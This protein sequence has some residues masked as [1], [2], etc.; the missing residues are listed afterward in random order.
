M[1]IIPTGAN[2][3]IFYGDAAVGRYVE[4]IN[5]WSYMLAPARWENLLFLLI[6]QQAP[7]MSGLNDRAKSLVSD[8]NTRLYTPDSDPLSEQAYTNLVWNIM[9]AG[10]GNVHLH[11][12]CACGTQQ[13]SYHW[14]QSLCATAG[15]NPTYTC[16]SFLY[17]MF[18]RDSL[19]YER[20][21]ILELLQASSRENLK[22]YTFFLSDTNSGG[23]RVET[24]ERWHALYLATL[25]NC[26]Q[27]MPLDCQAFS[28]GY[29]VLNANGKELEFIRR[30]RAC[31]LLLNEMDSGLPEV[32]ARKQILPEGLHSAEGLREWLQ[33]KVKNASLFPSSTA[34][35]NAWITIRMSANL[36]ARTACNRMKR[37]IDLNCV[38]HSTVKDK[39]RQAAWEVKQT[40]KE[41]LCSA[42]L[43]AIFPSHTL[44]EMSDAFQRIAEEKPQ[45]SICQ[46]PRRPWLS[47]KSA[48]SKHL[49]ECKQL[50][51]KRAY[52]YGIRSLVAIYA[53]A[54]AQVY[55]ELA[56][57]TQQLV[58]GI[59]DQ[60][61]SREK[62]RDFLQR[63]QDRLDRE[64][65]GNVLHLRQK[66]KN[67]SQ[68][69]DLLQPTLADLFQGMA[70][71]RYYQE[72]GILCEES[73]HKLLDLASSNLRKKLPADFQ[74]S[75][76]NMLHAEFHS[77]EERS[78]FFDSYLRS[79]PR[80][81]FNLSMTVGA[82]QS[83]F[84]VDRQLADQWFNAN[85]LFETNTDNAENLTLYPMPG[86]EAYDC[87]GDPG[88]YFSGQIGEERTQSLFAAPHHAGTAA[89]KQLDGAS[90]APQ[91]HTAAM[92]PTP[93]RN[94]QDVTLCPDARGHYMLRW[95]WRGNDKTATV[96]ATQ[97]GAQLGQI[98]VIPVEKF[99]RNGGA[100]DFSTD[101]LSGKPIPQGDLLISIRDENGRPYIQ[102]AKV[103][104]Y[105]ELVVYKLNG[106]CLTLKPAH[107][108]LIQRL[109][110][111]CPDINGQ[112][113]FLP[114]YAADHDEKYLFK[115]L[116]LQGGS[117]VEDPMQRTGT[118]ITQME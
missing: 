108:N 103:T 71:V 52:E 88:T 18:G 59:D 51:W 22:F 19:P 76:F 25:L 104:G 112:R 14:I 97:F 54:F 17:L 107:G 79:G 56:A 46:F 105:R 39:A 64:D 90:P 20:Q 96:I 35:K 72:D 4:L 62:A 41:K 98:S 61:K 101:V 58:S 28:L 5:N 68:E 78:R 116:T 111:Q 13:T 81:Y 2:I 27:K 32:D 49:E 21:Q 3:V 8:R 55:A 118:I 110:L 85:T 93:E 30:R 6:N 44:T 29:S 89:Y 113:I 86:K 114:L 73:W 33:E 63:E 23:G 77:Q 115:E 65:G 34:V 57:W 66:Y 80:M 9:G 74:G 45:I 37:F 15:K 47:T 11:L 42:L 100:M 75:F 83:F 60:G 36:D 82:G 87:L 106:N 102:N 48:M 99:Q 69:V 24:S 31:A 94:A 91:D 1:D 7:D 67:Y 109:V 43:T 117:V 38:Y 26:A 53:D 12:I 16:K 50:V 40:I 84:M 10:A 95:T 92:R 70:Q